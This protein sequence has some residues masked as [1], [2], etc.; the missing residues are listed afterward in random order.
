MVE[1]SFDVVVAGEDKSTTQGLCTTNMLTVP[2]KGDI[3]E[4]S[5]PNR[6]TT[7]EDHTFYRVVR[8]HHE[9]EMDEHRAVDAGTILVSCVIEPVDVDDPKTWE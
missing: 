9:L 7:E 4:V 5:V 1:V 3:V 8:V 6:K 2:R